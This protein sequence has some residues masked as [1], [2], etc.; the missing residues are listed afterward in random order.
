MAELIIQ[1]V[2]AQKHNLRAPFILALPTGE[3]ITI[4]KILRILPGKRIVAKTEGTEGARIIKLFGQTRYYEREISGYKLLQNTPVKTPALLKH[5]RLEIYGVCFYQYLDDIRPLDEVWSNMNMEQKM[6]SLDDLMDVLKKLYANN[7]FQTDLHLGNFVYEKGVLFALDPA[8]CKQDKHR[9][10]MISN[11]GMLM[12]QF[13]PLDWPL[14]SAA[15]TKNILDISAARVEKS[16]VSFWKHRKDDYLK[17]IFRDCSEIVDLGNKQQ[18]ILCY[19]NEL[20]DAFVSVLRDPESAIRKGK[21]LKD[22]RSTM[23]AR[24]EVGEKSYAIKRYHNANRFTALRR[25]LK[26]GRA[27]NSWRFAHLLGMLGVKTPKPIALVEIS[28]NITSYVSYYISEFVDVNHAFAVFTHVPP[29]AAQ[30]DGIGKVFRIWKWA[31][32][33]HGDCKSTNWLVRDDDLMVID[34]DAMREVSRP[35]PVDRE[36]FL[37]DW[38]KYPTLFSLFKHQLRQESVP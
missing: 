12:A 37:R 17:K 18:Q 24:I 6:C 2:F 11:L 4:E 33:E 27:K 25:L 14:V 29:T 13:P 34:L 30:L 7:V 9:D 16:A 32:I 10:A 15:I 23:V 20:S 19:R 35:G 8:S 38:K 1:E 26:Q 22:S 31:G 36:R 21:I 3:K 5:D 28:N